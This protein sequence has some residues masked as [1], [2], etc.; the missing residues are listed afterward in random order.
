MPVGGF[1]SCALLA[2]ALPVHFLEDLA[3]FSAYQSK[4]KIVEAAPILAEY[5]SGDVEIGPFGRIGAFLW[6]YSSLTKERSDIHYQLCP[7]IDFGP[8]WAYDLKFCEG[9]KW[10]SAV[11][12]WDIT[13][14]S[15]TPGRRGADA[16]TIYEVWYETSLE[17]EYV[18]PTLRYR[19]AL[20]DND[21]DY[22]RVGLMKPIKVVENL[23]LIPRVEAEL[24]SQDFF[25]YRYGEMEGGR[26]HS[27][28]L[29]ALLCRLCVSYAFAKNLNLRVE[30]TQFDLMSKDARHQTHAP[31][32]R[33]YLFYSVGL[34]YRF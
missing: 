20:I 2:A 27:G 22:Y 11:S 12:W 9:L 14:P 28:G 6:T 5:V 8:K 29:A 18:V 33:D 32:R 31:N 24:G 13:Q 1:L 21:W 16:D 3:F 10:K 7:E 19:K 30:A 34:T 4:G 23:T 15:N 25:D 17:N 26:S